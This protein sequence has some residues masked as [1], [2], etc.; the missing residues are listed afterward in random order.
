MALSEHAFS[1]TFMIHLP[2]V[3][4]MVITSKYISITLFL[5]LFAVNWVVHIITDDTKANKLKINLVQ[6][7]LIHICQIFI[8]WLIYILVS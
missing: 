2:L 1:W 7:Q 8:T 3:V 5:T 6:D 4:A